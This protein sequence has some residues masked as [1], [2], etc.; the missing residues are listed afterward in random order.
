MEFGSPPGAA[1]DAVHRDEVM[2]QLKTQIAI[3]NAQELLQVAKTL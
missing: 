3:V 1:K 2:D